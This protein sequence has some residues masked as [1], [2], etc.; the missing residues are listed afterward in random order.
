MAKTEKENFI[1]PAFWYD[2]LK[3]DITILTQQKMNLQEERDLL[4]KENK[5]LR[6]QVEFLEMENYELKEGKK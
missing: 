1:I 4:E 3:K 5:L 6:Q 2:S